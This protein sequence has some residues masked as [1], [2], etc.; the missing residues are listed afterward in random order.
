[1]GLA[2][3]VAEFAT[4]AF[5]L[6]NAI[7]A[8]AY[9]PQI[10]RIV[11]DPDGARAV[12]CATWS[13]FAISHLTTVLYALLAAHDWTMVEV[14]AGNALA[15]TTIIGLTLLKRRQ[16]QRRPIECTGAAN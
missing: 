5:T 16:E 14:F 1:M 2:M 9:L 12:S 15:C 7:R 8:L 4:A 3:T 11:Q 13:L 10:V 6:C